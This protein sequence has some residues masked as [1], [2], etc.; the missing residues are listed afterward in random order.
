MTYDQKPDYW[1]DPTDTAELAALVAADVNPERIEITPDGTHWITLDDHDQLA[2]G[3][4]STEDDGPWW[5][6]TL[7]TDGKP[8]HVAI[9]E[10]DNLPDVTGEIARLAR[11]Y[12]HD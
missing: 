3:D 10:G 7:Y 5:I 11:K 8:V 4:D 6:G 9:V 2:F 12:H 1:I